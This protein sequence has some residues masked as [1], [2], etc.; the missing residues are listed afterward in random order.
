[1]ATLTID[2]I[3]AIRSIGGAEDLHW[4]PD[5]WQVRFV[6]NLGDGPE[7]WAVDVN[8]GLLS[9]LTVG[10]GGV[11]H[12]AAFMPKRSP[13][14]DQI[15]YV[16]DKTGADEVWLWTG[17]GAPDR[18]L[19]RFGARVEAFA[20]S[21][22]GR[23]LAVA[24]SA[25]GTFDIYLVDVAACESRKL[26]DHENYEV[27]PQFTPD[28]SRILYVRLNADWTD[29][30]VISINPDGTDEHVIE[31]DT[32]FFDYHYG[33][34][35]G[36]PLISPDGGTFLFRS[37]RSGWENI[38]ARAIDGTGEAWQLAPAHADQ[39]DA[40]WSPDGSKVAYIENHNGTLGLRIA[41]G[42]GSG[43]LDGFSPRVGVYRKPAWSPDGRKIAFLAGNPTTPN[44]VWVVDLESGARR[45][46]TSS[47]PAG[48][49][50]HLVQPEKI[51][52]ESWDGRE[53]S[54]YIYRPE[55]RPENSC[56][57]L[58]WIHGGPTSQFL[59]T[60]DAQVQYFVSQ[61]YAVMLP[62][63]RGSSGY[64]RE[65]EDL[66]NGDW[67]HG[68][69][70]D[71]IAGA[72]WLKSLPEVDPDHIGITGTSY[73]GIMSMAAVVW[74]APG[75]FQAA[76]PMSGYCD[77]L[78]MVGEEEIRHNKMM[79]YEFGKLPEAEEIYRKCSPIY[80][81]QQAATPCFIIHGT[82]HYPGSTS[83][84]DFAMALEAAYKPYWYKAYEDNSYYVYSKAGVR[85]MLLDMTTFFDFYLKGI[86]HP[87]LDS[88]G[89]KTRL[90]GVIPYRS[91]ISTEPFHPRHDS[92]R[93]GYEN[94]DA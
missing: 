26:T 74:A 93:Y 48:L 14:A 12:L 5:G 70:R 73:G 30:T 91:W 66:N 22:D 40:A 63:V 3:L 11:G 54:A 29:H 57:G 80:W 45:R 2:Q 58:M 81:T 92:P 76:A 94:G 21:P 39:Y 13:V 53:I 33:R 68:D 34:E 75:V 36:Y 8:D 46:L 23:S 16:S 78:Y 18:Q 1:M 15:A 37:H 35:F 44:E 82:G 90:S 9:Q 17:D 62:N 69:L 31:E 49:E 4:S 86:P 28:G 7:I 67:G 24:S 61:G 79:D 64:G 50:E 89:I 52:Y 59:D 72:K 47:V 43:E 87:P 32:S 38:W 10:M 77:F 88:L 42:D 27:Y 60:F 6:A 83:S 55:G 19:T 56:P 25:A 65:F 20:W 41:A 71:V 84:L 51:R 85:Q